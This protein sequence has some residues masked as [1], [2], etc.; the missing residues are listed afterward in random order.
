MQAEAIPEA[1]WRDN[2][3]VFGDSLGSEH[4]RG[5]LVDLDGNPLRI[6]APLVSTTFARQSPGENG[7]ATCSF[8]I[9]AQAGAGSNPP[10]DSGARPRRFWRLATSSAARD[11][12][13]RDPDRGHIPR[14]PGRLPRSIER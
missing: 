11:R 8:S 9:N 10:R 12:L 5:D 7:T 1:L 13:A 3:R 2:A 4:A 6:Y 14:C